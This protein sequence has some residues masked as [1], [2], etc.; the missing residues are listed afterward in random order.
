VPQGSPLSPILFSLYLTSLY[1]LLE[2]D[3]RC[4]V[5]RFADDTNIL[6]FGRSGQANTQ[7]LEAIW[8]ICQGWARTRGMQFEPSK[9]ELLHFTRARAAVQDPVRLGPELISPVE[10]ARF[11]GVWLDRKLRW[12]AHLREACR[13]FA[14]QKLALTR[15][16][17]S[18]WGLGLIRA[19][20]IYTKVI[21]SS[22]V[23]GA[24]AY[25]LPTQDGRSPRGIVKKLAK[26]QSECL[27]AVA[28]A[29]R[30][31][32]VASL[33]TETWVPPLDLYLGQRVA[34]FERRLQ[35]SGIGDL[36][37]GAC[38]GVA[39]RLW[40]RQRRTRRTRLSAEGP[41]GAD[42]GAYKAWWAEKWAP[43]ETPTCDRLQRD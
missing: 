14:I 10:S 34:E 37:T 38:A 18:V 3:G 5:V 32:P 31:T 4:S 27:R 43:E 12:K 41:P 21:R 25:H 29:Y 19:R 39:A 7:T 28:G 30:A 22:L 9:S 42:T 26:T 24:A 20:E 35:R 17:G 16:T 2:A 23:Y 15:L 11:L 6:V 13:K 36:I 40:R 33:E 8:E 1:R